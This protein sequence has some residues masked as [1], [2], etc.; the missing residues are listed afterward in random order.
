MDDKIT[1]RLDD[2]IVQRA[3]DGTVTIAQKQGG[4][5]VRIGLLIACVIVAFLCGGGLV[6]SGVMQLFNPESENPF[7]FIFFGVF[8]MAMFGYFTYYQFKQA[9]T[10]SRHE[11]ITISPI[12]NTIKIGDRVILFSEIVDVGAIK[13]PILVTDAVAIRFVLHVKPNEEIEIGRKVMDSNNIRQM[14]KFEI[15]TI[16][17]LKQALRKS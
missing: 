9:S 8:V 4:N 16:T 14:D 13:S 15:E 3:E 5:F 11:P 2:V 17:L 1:L 6:V 7:G 12:M 10:G